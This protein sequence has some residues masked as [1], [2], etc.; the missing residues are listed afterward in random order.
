[1]QAVGN[2][3]G[4]PLLDAVG[5][6]EVKNPR[7]VKVKV[8]SPCSANHTLFQFDDGNPAS[9]VGDARKSDALPP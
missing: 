6:H 7:G 3:D 4:C 8:A 2:P 9:A 1:V 5:P